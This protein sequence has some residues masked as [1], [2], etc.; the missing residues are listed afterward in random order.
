MAKANISD[1]VITAGLI[2][3]GGLVAYTLYKT[4]Q[5]GEKT[6]D[7]V[8]T[9]IDDTQ[10]YITSGINRITGAPKYFWD[11]TIGQGG[12]GL[13][14]GSGYDNLVS[15]VT[16]SGDTRTNNRTTGGGQS[17]SRRRR[18][19][20]EDANRTLLGKDPDSWGW[21]YGPKKGFLFG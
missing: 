7:Y 3:G 4:F 9:K 8:G 21:G 2:V 17:G 6:A 14:G 20:T 11:E 18:D 19:N 10:N 15:R 16:N 1:D 5:A 13:T 12:L